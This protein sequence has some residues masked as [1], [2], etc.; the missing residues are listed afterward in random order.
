M[1]DA[2]WVGADGNEIKVCNVDDVDLWNGII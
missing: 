1:F 2:R